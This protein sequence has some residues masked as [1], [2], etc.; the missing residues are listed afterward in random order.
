[1]AT[2]ERARINLYLPKK[3]ADRIQAEASDLG[4]S[5]NAYVISMLSHYYNG[6][7]ASRNAAKLQ[8]ILDDWKE[9]MQT[10]DQAKIESAREGIEQMNFFT[11]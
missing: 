2:T 3:L 8:K 9:G 11:E 1:M 7:D 10:L 5:S 4:M 6:L